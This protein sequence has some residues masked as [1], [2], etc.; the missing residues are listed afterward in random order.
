MKEVGDTPVV[1]FDVDDT[2]IMWGIIEY[3]TPARDDVITFTDH[4][5]LTFTCRYHKAHVEHIKSHKS[6]GHFVIV[7]SAGGGVWAQKAV[8]ILGL[9]DYVDQTMSKPSWYIDDKKAEYWMGSPEFL[10]E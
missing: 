1:C 6:R 2:L 7:W 8:E 10:E 5:G 4:A 3:T 9:K